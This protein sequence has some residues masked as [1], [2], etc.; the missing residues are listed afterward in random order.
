MSHRQA[1][2][3]GQD[4][5]LPRDYKYHFWFMVALVAALIG[6]PH[7]VVLKNF[8]AGMDGNLLNA[9]RMGIAALVCAP[10]MLI[11]VKVIKRNRGAFRSL[12]IASISMAAS[13]F[14]FT[15]SIR[16]APAS[17]VAILQLLAPVMLAVYSARF[18]HEKLTLKAVLG[19][20]C[21][22]LG[23]VVIIS[24]PF[25]AVQTTSHAFYPIATFLM[26]LNAVTYPLYTVHVRK[27][28][29][30]YKIPMF[31][32]LG[33]VYSFVTIVSLLLWAGTGAKLPGQFTTGM[34]FAVL[35]SGLLVS[36]IG[37]AM[38]I[39]SYERIGS[40]PIVVLTYLEVFVA[41]LLPLFY[42]GEQMTASTI[43]GGIFI[44]L[45]VV[46]AESH[47]YRHGK[48]TPRLPHRT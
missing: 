47:R 44:F 26:L 6:A 19:I 14:S 22:F 1:H 9:L 24:V 29:T 43:V 18:F 41:I 12:M 3:R 39:W 45:G 7:G 27:M 2:K 5:S 38:Q 13:V 40:V 37:R 42:L 32:I 15:F 10:S 46:L 34:L 21:A 20:G 48:K 8:A 17:Y 33:Y 35:F 28:N 30:D 31:S 11:A 16:Y 25:Y 36:G 23:A 4:N